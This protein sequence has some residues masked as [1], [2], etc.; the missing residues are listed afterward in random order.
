MAGSLGTLGVI[1][2]AT[3][4]VRPLPEAAALLACDVPDFD[5]AEK[6]LASLI[7]SD[8]RPVAVEFSNSVWHGLPTKAWQGQEPSTP[9]CS[10]RRDARATNP[11]A[12]SAVGPRAGWQRGPAVRRV[13]GTGGRSGMDA[14]PAAPAVDGVGNDFADVD[15]PAGHRQAMAM[16]FRVSGRR[17]DQR[18]AEQVVP[19]IA[20][21]QAIVPDAGIE[22]HA[23]DGVI[24]VQLPS[25]ACGKGAEGSG[26]RGEGSDKRTPLARLRRGAGVRASA[27]NRSFRACDAGRC[28]RRQDGRAKMPVGEAPSR[29]DVW[30]PPRPEMGVMRAIKERFDPQNILNPGD[31]SS[32]DSP[33]DN[34]GDNPTTNPAAGIGYEEFLRCIHCGLCT[35]TCPT[36][37]EA[38]DENDGPRGRI[39]LMR[40]VADGQPLS[41]RMRRHLELCLDCRACETACPS[42]VRYGRLIEPF[43]LAVE[44]ADR[45]PEKGFDWFRELVLFRVFPYAERMRRLLVLTPLAQRTG[46]LPLA[47]RMGLLR[48]MPGRLGRMARLLPAELKSGSAAAAVPAGGGAEACPRGVFRRLRG[49]RRLSP[50][51]LGHP[52][53]PASR[54]AATCSFR[55]N[56]AAAGRSISTPATAA[57]QGKWPTPI[58]SPSSSTG[59]MR[60][61]ST[62]RAAGR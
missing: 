55:P 21:L 2:Q 25:P 62:M 9:G 11:W 50:R 12:E 39:Q 10:S 26:E 34:N 37:A 52:P 24:R 61:S 17:A 22:A 48:L 60:S 30:G 57:R 47:E 44:Q 13:R 42:G 29:E 40:L 43:R 46:V 49:R 23:A 3:L 54:T 14:R 20:A 56:R 8:V 27:S 15:A 19:A 41:D 7:G 58:W 16:D 51:P 35:P 31:L 1:T 38:G 45:R 18:P 6:L 59:T 28:S 33:M 4:M 53:R 36:F 5:L 32:I